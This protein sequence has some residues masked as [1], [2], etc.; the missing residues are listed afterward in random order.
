M[1]VFDVKSRPYAVKHKA[2]STL[3]EASD[4]GLMLSISQQSS[5]LR[6]YARN[7][8]TSFNKVYLAN[9]THLWKSLYT[10]HDEID[11]IIFRIG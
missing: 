2:Q 10:V 11:N 9:E 1:L 4:D 7:I 6:I 8:Q 3:E 5:F